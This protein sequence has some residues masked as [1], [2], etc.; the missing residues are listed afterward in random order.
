[1]T[2][3]GWITTDLDVGDGRRWGAGG[4]SE[5]TEVIEREAAVRG[6][7]AVDDADIT[8]HRGFVELC[9]V[10]RGIAVLIVFVHDGMPGLSVCGGFDLVPVAVIYQRAVLLGVLV[11]E[12]GLDRVDAAGL[13]EIDLQPFAGVAC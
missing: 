4:A 2:A 7:V 8:G 12:V 1:M 5:N 6:R 9:I 13:A 3:V 11:G 10:V